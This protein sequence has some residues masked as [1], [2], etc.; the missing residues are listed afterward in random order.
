MS[1][2]KKTDVC[3]IGAGPS[4]AST[5]LMLSKLKVDHCIVDKAVFPRDKTCGDGL[6]L[7]AYK[8]MKLLGGD[9]FDEFLRSPNFLH[10]K[11]IKLHVN[12][13]L[14]IEFKESEDR[15]MIISYAKRIDFDYFLI[16]HLSDEYTSKY[17]G[18]GVKSLEIKSDGV[19]VKLKNGEE[20]LAKIVVGA[21][22]VQAIVSKK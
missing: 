22:G 8:S 18:N 7:Y 13:H 5:S 2:I 14:N 11:R 3:V 1:D 12:N 21:D 10:S 19:L 9:L 6:I 15:D 20:I 16:N 17:F 4:G